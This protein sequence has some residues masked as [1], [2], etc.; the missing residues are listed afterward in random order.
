MKKSYAD[1]SVSHRDLNMHEHP[2]FDFYLPSIIVYLF[3]SGLWLCYPFYS[4]GSFEKMS[5][6]GAILKIR[7][8]SIIK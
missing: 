6:Y 3:L 1:T 8:D 7:R 5:C 2:V 4:Y